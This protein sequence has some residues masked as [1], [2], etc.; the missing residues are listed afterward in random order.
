MGNGNSAANILGWSNPSDYSANSFSNS[1]WY[2]PNYTSSNFKSVS[3]D[4]LTGNNGADILMGFTAGLFSSTS[5][6]TSIK[7]KNEAASLYVQN[8]TAYLYGISNA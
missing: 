6:I 4:T 8:T 1:S 5:A 7:I 2:I 3:V